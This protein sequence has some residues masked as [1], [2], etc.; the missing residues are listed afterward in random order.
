MPIKC[1]CIFRLTLVESIPEN[2]TYPAGSPTH[3]S[4]YEGWMNLLK[5]ANESIDIASSYWNLRGKD[6]WSDPTDWQVSHT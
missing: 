1:M 6:A 2:L 3:L 5:L 4:V